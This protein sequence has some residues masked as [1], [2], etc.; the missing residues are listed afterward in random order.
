MECYLKIYQYYTGTNT[1]IHNTYMAFLIVNICIYVCIYHRQ[2]NAPKFLSL[3]C[4]KYE[5]TRT[6]RGRTLEKLVFSFMLILY[7]TGLVMTVFSKASRLVP[8]A[9]FE[10]Q[11][12]LSHQKMLLPQHLSPSSRNS[13]QPS[14]HRKKV[15]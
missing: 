2:N 7:T 5:G 8:T 15:S 9:T 14:F 12:H 11:L 6:G 10:F 3:P 1:E 13:I 4:V